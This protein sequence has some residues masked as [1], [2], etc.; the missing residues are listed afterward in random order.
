MCNKIKREE[1][2]SKI[3]QKK[4]TKE[5]SHVGN[6]LVKSSSGGANNDNHHHDTK[7][8]K[9]QTTKPAQKIESVKFATLNDDIDD[10]FLDIGGS[11]EDF[12]KVFGSVKSMVTNLKST[13]MGATDSGF[14]EF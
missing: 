13:V 6:K 1:N 3:E 4:A 7:N 12:S 14:D 8:S 5:T 9:Q 11:F 10:G 2:M